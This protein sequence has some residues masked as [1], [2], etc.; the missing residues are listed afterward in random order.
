MFLA[1]LLAPLLLVG[2][3]EDDTESYS[4]HCDLGTPVLYPTSAAPG[5]TVTATARSLTSV[6]DTVVRVGATDAIVSDV[7]RPGCDSC[8]QCREKSQCTSCDDC[9]ECAAD[10]A[11]CVESVV[12]AVPMLGDGSYGVS[13][14]NVH[15]QSPT[16]TLLVERNGSADT[17]D[18][19][20]DDSGD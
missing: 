20:D 14:T 10:C 17:G 18:T 7:Q 4:L 2:G 1:L 15:G 6:Q 19:G 5:Q 12:F 3:C 9:D 11:E 13:I 8:D 16:A